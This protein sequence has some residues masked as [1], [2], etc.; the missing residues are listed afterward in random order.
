MDW[1]LFD[2]DPTLPS[3]C[4]KRKRSEHK[5][6]MFQDEEFSSDSDDSR[7]VWPLYY[8]GTVEYSN[9]RTPL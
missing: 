3:A 5:G 8:K 7:F 4:R 2:S 6:P 1:T 9:K